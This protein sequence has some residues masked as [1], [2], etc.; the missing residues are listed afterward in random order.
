[1][2]PGTTRSSLIEALRDPRN[3]T[4]WAEFVKHYEPLVRR[5][6][7]RWGVPNHDADAVTNV[8][9]AAVFKGWA[10][11]DPSRKFR[12]WLSGVAKNAALDWHRERRRQTRAIDA[13]AR[14]YADAERP[15]DD[16]LDSVWD[17]EY[18]A[19]LQKALAKAIA[20][21]QDQCPEQQWR[22]FREHAMTGH[23]APEV[24]ERLGISTNLVY[25]NCSRALE[26]VRRVFMETYLD[27]FPDGD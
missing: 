6:V 19:W 9:F 25:T 3:S 22:C 18:R 5:A 10:N 7:T 8:V 4:R 14:I 21:A 20:V 16:L 17:E 23:S 11:Y 12:A 26:K 15:F 1:M 27:E 13:A 2:D 24:A